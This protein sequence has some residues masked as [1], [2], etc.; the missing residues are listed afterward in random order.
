MECSRGTY[1]FN[2]YVDGMWEGDDAGAPPVVE[3]GEAFFL[4]RT[5][6]S[7]PGT[8]TRSFFSGTLNQRRKQ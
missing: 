7:F 1:R 8:W 2:Q 3:I 4:I 5:G 6:G